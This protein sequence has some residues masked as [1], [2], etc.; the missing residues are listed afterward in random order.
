MAAAIKSTRSTYPRILSGLIHYS[1]YVTF[2]YLLSWA[3]VTSLNCSVMC[4]PPWWFECYFRRSS[5]I[6]CWLLLAVLSDYFGHLVT[7]TFLLFKFRFRGL[8]GS[9]AL[10]FNSWGR[11]SV[12]R[13]I[14]GT[15]I[16]KLVTRSLVADGHRVEVNLNS[17]VRKKHTL[18]EVRCDQILMRTC[19]VRCSDSEFSLW[20]FFFVTVRGL[21]KFKTRRSLSDEYDG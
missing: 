5:W 18:P 1:S 10:L 7:S 8:P 15:R 9:T 17:R 11:A 2:K 4:K 6:H 12:P 13:V 16:C 20:Q 21:T 14:A 3:F 19:I